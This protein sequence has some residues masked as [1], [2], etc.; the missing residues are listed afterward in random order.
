MKFT[1]SLKNNF[2][3]RRL[4]N[5]GKSASSPLLVI[6]CRRNGRRVSRLGITVGKKV[7]NA[8]VRNKLRRRL[9]E[10]YR[11]NEDFFVR[12]WDIVVVARV[13]SRYAPFSEL[14][15]DFLALSSRLG[16]FQPA[17]KDG[18]QT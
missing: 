16:L 6:Y 17:G 5:R 10:S 1:E 3:F 18:R 15:S 2:E 9:R 4:Y 8:V 7:G 12:G 14:C 11:I 13:K